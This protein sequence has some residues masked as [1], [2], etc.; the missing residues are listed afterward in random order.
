MLFEKKILVVDDSEAVRKTLQTFLEIEGYE[1]IIARSGAEGFKVAKEEHPDLII[2]DF[3]MPNINGYHFAKMLKSDPDTQDI[4]VI[5]IS[6]KGD[7]VGEKFKEL[8]GA[9][10]YLTKPFTT[11]QLK[12]LITRILKAE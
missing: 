8:T 10:D 3:V 5:L 9:I 11:R 4:P 7:K 6:S 2:T 1:V 12:Q